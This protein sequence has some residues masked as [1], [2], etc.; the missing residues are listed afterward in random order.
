MQKRIPKSLR[1][2]LRKEKA[3]IR[4]EFLEPD[5][6]EQKIRSI[7][8]RIGILRNDPAKA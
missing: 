7:Y 4:K 1:K 3:R 2:Y 5:L 8:A 6:R